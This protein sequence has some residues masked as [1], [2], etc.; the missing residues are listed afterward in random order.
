MSNYMMYLLFVNPEMLMAGTRRNLF[1][2][3]YDELKAI[4]RGDK[5]PAK[6]TEKI[7]DIISER[8]KR[9]Y[10][11]RELAQRIAAVVDG[12]GSPPPDGTQQQQGD[13]IRD[14]WSI[15]EVLSG[16]PEEK[17]WDVIEGVWVEMLCFFAARCRGYLRAKGLATGIEYLTCVW[18]LQYYMGME[19]LAAKLQR[20][21]N[22]HRSAGENGYDA[23]TSRVSRE[24]TGQ[25]QDIGPS[26]NDATDIEPADGPSN[27][28]ST[29]QPNA[30]GQWPYKRSDATRE[31][32][33]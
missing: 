27:T 31:E 19:T 30:E 12:G 25:E 4:V 11:E 7:E 13:I 2:T 23:S 22:H 16:L 15:A 17:V 21:D 8:D 3:A 24:A 18:L 10:K 32:I 33:V 26:S 14:A 29:A 5:S 20:V 9:P 28:G 6:E 1:T